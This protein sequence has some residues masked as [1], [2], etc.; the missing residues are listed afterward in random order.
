MR[1]IRHQ[2]ARG[3]RTGHGE[4][5]RKGCS[6]RRE[7]RSSVCGSAQRTL[8]GWKEDRDNGELP[9]KATLHERVVEAA[10]R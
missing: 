7:P 5:L 9:A 6:L 3:W 8:P 1:R 10:L 4:G 2:A